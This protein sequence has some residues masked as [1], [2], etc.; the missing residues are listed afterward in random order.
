MGGALHTLLL[1]CVAVDTN[2]DRTLDPMEVESLF[3][4]ELKKVYKDDMD[5]MEAHE[6]MARMREYAMSEVHAMHATFTGATC[7]VPGPCH[8]LIELSWVSD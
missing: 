2:A 6:D 3:Y 1:H 8:S 7:R 5:G 4:S